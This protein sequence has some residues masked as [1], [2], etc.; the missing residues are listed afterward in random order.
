[1]CQDKTPISSFLD[2]IEKVRFKN[3]FRKM[4]HVL[5]H[6]K[7]LDEKQ[8]SPFDISEAL[9]LCVPLNS[10]QHRRIPVFF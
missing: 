7:K 2:P 4:F 8:R 3:S 6:T 1:M 9:V 5:V 10:T